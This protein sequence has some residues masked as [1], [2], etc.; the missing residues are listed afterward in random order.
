MRMA[1]LQEYRK[2]T[3]SF[4]PTAGAHPVAPT[5]PDPSLTPRPAV[6][7]PT[8]GARQRETG[9]RERRE[10]CHARD[11]FRRVYREKQAH[12]ETNATLAEALQYGSVASRSS[13]LVRVTHP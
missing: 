3:R 4:P 7:A 9:R 1:C 5:L 8:L 12:S 13:A 2:I 11:G 6:E 10:N